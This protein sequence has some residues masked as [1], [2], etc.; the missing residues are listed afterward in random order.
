MARL[1]T[2]AVLNEVP[3]VQAFASQNETAAEGVSGGAGGPPGVPVVPLL[4]PATL[5]TR[6]RR[7][8]TPKTLRFLIINDSGIRVFMVCLLKMESK[9][10][11]GGRWR[12]RRKF[13]LELCRDWARR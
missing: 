4:H 7:H 10:K 6:R 8:D 2:E 3:G 5:S 12:H 13:D 9:R 11:T 1:L